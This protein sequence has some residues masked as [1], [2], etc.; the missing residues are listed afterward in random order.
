MK[1]TVLLTGLFLAA[2][3]SD[4]GVP[5]ISFEKTVSKS[6]G[7]ENQSLFQ[8]DDENLRKY[9]F[10]LAD[11]YIKASDASALA[12]HVSNALIISV[13]ADIALGTINGISAIAQSRAILS[14][15]LLSQRTAYV[16]PNEVARAYRIAAAQAACIA[17]TTSTDTNDVLFV[18][19]KSKS[20]LRSRLVRNPVELLDLIDIFRKSSVIAKLDNEDSIR[21]KNELN[22]ARAKVKAAE[23]SSSEKVSLAKQVKLNECLLET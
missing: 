6:A 10:A 17:T 19:H 4:A 7:I 11:F 8:M 14:G 1:P 18:M 13:A 22:I 12:N 5:G 16:A 21:D 23:G 3:C 2:A 9:N 15:L 20:D